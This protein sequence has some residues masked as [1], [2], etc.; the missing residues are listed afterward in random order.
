MELEILKNNFKVEHVSFNYNC[1]AL[2]VGFNDDSCA[3]FDLK[4]FNSSLKAPLNV[5]VKIL[6]LKTS[7]DIIRKINLLDSTQIFQCIKLINNFLI[8]FI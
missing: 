4:E 8:N 5:S 3:I 2:C 7:N 6:E 1:T